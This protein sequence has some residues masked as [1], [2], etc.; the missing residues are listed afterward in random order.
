MK[1]QNILHEPANHKSACDLEY[2]SEQLNFPCETI[3]LSVWN[4]RVYH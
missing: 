3:K 1:K 2:V 4:Q